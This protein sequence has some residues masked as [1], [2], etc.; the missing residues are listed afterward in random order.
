MQAA[1]ARRGRVGGNVMRWTSLLSGS[2]IAALCL[3]T[4]A[5]GDDSNPT[6]P[7]SAPLVFTAELLPSNEVP[8]VSNAESVAH[9]AVQV[10]I[11]ATRDSSGNVTGGTVRFDVQ[12]AGLAENTTFTGAHI[13]SAVAGVNGAIVV[14][15]ALTPGLAP[16]QNGTAVWAFQNIPISAALLNQIIANPSAFYFNVHT[17]SNPGGVARGQLRRTL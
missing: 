13:H 4:V 12:L 7:S 10:T 1:A 5:C 6:A 2:L 3:V 11:D 17:F 15:S 9:G 16:I 14:N 8:A